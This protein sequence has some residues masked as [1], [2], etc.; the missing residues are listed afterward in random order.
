MQSL[1][2]F[3]PVFILFTAGLLRN[4]PGSRMFRVGRRASIALIRKVQS[5]RLDRLISN[6]W[7]Q[8]MSIVH[9][10]KY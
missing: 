4:K 5:L 9:L 2:N 6:C 3:I 1:S 10:A 7:H 8:Y